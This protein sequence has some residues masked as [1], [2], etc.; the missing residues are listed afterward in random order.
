[1]TKPCSTMVSALA[2]NERDTA[3]GMVSQDGF[4]YR[5]DLV[6]YRYIGEGVID[7]N[8]EYKS[9]MFLPND[10]KDDLKVM[11]VGIEGSKAVCRVYNDNEDK[12][13]HYVHE[14]PE[15]KICSKKFTEVCL[16]KS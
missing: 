11:A 4:V 8:V 6:K 1:M 3:I 14:E 15:D 13:L 5:Y 2:F 9:V 10:P 16:I 7:R 12:E